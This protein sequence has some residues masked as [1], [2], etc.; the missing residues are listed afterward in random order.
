MLLRWIGN[1]AMNRVKEM[2]F[3][4]CAA[5][6]GVC[7]GR[8]EVMVKLMVI[9]PIM[10]LRLTSTLLIWGR[11]IHSGFR[12]SMPVSPSWKH[13]CSCTFIFK[14]WSSPLAPPTVALAIICTWWDIYRVF[15]HLLFYETITLFL[16]ILVFS[17]SNTTTPSRSLY[18]IFVIWNC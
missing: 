11:T 17:C 16:Q 18:E 9:A 13:A 12:Y 15:M 10:K 7:A 1:I 14:S 5:E 6:I 8:S 2:A 3:D 4:F